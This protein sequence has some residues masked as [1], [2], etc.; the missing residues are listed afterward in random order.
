MSQDF[1]QISVRPFSAR[2]TLCLVIASNLCA[3]GVL[4][5]RKRW[6]PEQALE[7]CRALWRQ[8]PFWIG[9]AV[10]GALA[11]ISYGFALHLPFLFDD[12]P[13]MT[14]LSHHNWI[15][16]WAHSSENAYY[17]PL[18]FTIYQLGRL[19]PPGARQ[20]ALHAVSLLV[21]W[22]GAVL[23]M[24][25]A[26]MWGKGRGQALLAAVLFVVFPFTF[27]TVPWITA[28]SHPLVVALTLLAVYAA[29]RAERDNAPG[30]WGTSL[31]ATALAPFAH[32]SGPM[33]S[34]IVGGV[35]LIRHGLRS[36]R[37]L[38][39]TFL[40]VAFNV[41]G[42]LLRNIIPGVGRA[43]WFGLSDWLQNTMFFLHGLVYP[44]TP[45]IGWLVRTRGWQ[46]FRLV[47]IAA[48]AIGIVTLWL[49]GRSRD[50]RWVTSGLWW[51][52]CGALPAAISFRYG[53]LYIAPRLYALS[54][55]GA[56]MLWAYIITELARAVRYV[57][58][59]RLVCV[60]FAGAIVIQ[61]VAFIHR[62]RTLFVTLDHLYQKVLQ[63]AEDEQ[64]APLGFVNLPTSLAWPD[65]TYA[66]ILETVIFVPYYS[67]VGQFMEVN[68]KWRASDA[69]LYPPV[70]Q[71]TYEVWGMEG[72][73]LGWEQM[74]QFAIEHRTV[75]LTR[76]QGVGRFVLREVGAITPDAE[77]VAEPLARFEG[78]P[79]IESASAAE[80]PEG[81]WAITLTWSAAGPV[82]GDIFVHVRDA[83]HN[84]VTQADGPALGGMV[85]I[86][87]WQAG[88][89]IRDVRYV[90]L[91]PNGG[92]YTVQVGVYDSAGR[93]P[94]YV[95]DTR[96]PEDAAPVATILQMNANER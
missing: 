92:P 35:L 77:P 14:W 5:G 51:W 41:G 28:L 33:C 72:E 84:L 10:T 80:T 74:R 86:W 34:V 69:V 43:H 27:H 7:R 52:A 20:V 95:G 37:R 21:H 94:A 42:V 67:N 15:D 3:L 47:Q 24:L 82:D 44:V 91:P 60:L 85:P 89:R 23:M 78:G 75:W 70:F 64:N 58:G 22:A 46:D 29:L 36:R 73:G 40:G 18:A 6:Q 31:L 96:C 4:C 53:D 62:Q 26:Q 39:V 30:W 48:L 25:F 55:V 61:N 93:F 63:A 17:R 2:H 66:M 90:T 56:V 1:Q 71:D 81:E 32:E 11:F 87:L 49:T 88:D 54:S 59:R 19:L 50:W 9:T 16:I 45:L 68:R 65:K 57:W 83:N 76:Y 38:T 13:I 79:V 8:Y 12:L